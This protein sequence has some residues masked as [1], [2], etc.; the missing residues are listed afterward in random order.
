MIHFSVWCGMPLE[1]LW[2]LVVLFDARAA[3]C[4]LTAHSQLYTAICCM[5][6]RHSHNDERL[7][8]LRLRSSIR[9]DATSTCNCST[10]CF[11]NLYISHSAYN[12][13]LGRATVTYS[14]CLIVVR[15]ACF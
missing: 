12:Y 11:L 4:W 8:R 6:S 5:T 15:T 9:L 3:V 2:L 7:L 1:W 13:L 14:L 10:T